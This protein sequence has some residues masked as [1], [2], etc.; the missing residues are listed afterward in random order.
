MRDIWLLF[1]ECHVNT[2]Q[3]SSQQQN[4][5]T[6]SWQKLILDFHLWNC[7]KIFCC[8]SHPIYSIMLW[9]LKLTDN[10]LSKFFQNVLSTFPVSLK[11]S[12]SQS[13]RGA[14]RLVTHFIL[15]PSPSPPHSLWPFL[16]SVATPPTIIMLCSLETQPETP[17]ICQLHSNLCL[18]SRPLFRTPDLYIQLILNI[19][20][21]MSNRHVKLNMSKTE[22]LIFPQNFLYHSLTHLIFLHLL[23]PKLFKSSLVTTI[24]TLISY[25]KSI[26]EICWICVKVCP[27]S[28]HFSLLSSWHKGKITC[29]LIFYNSIFYTLP[30]SAYIPTPLTILKRFYWNKTIYHTIHLFKVS[31]PNVSHCSQLFNHYFK[32]F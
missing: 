2:Q 8:V 19:A 18:K 23:R 12:S 29:F 31:N 27:K 25:I 4:G 20:I 11:R 7:E 5:R 6:Q 26:S 9:L 13:H 10:S 14:T 32:E 24:L 28:N 15:A 16:L 1:S 21:W 22:L 3:E 17:S 30:N